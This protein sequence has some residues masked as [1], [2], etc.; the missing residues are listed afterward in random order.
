[1]EA[2]VNPVPLLV[3]AVVLALVVPTVRGLRPVRRRALERFARRVDLPLP[4]GSH[5]ELAGRLTGRNLAAELGGCAG[6]AAAGVAGLAFGLPASLPAPGDVAQPLW[7]LIAAGAVLAGGALG[8]GTYGANLATRRHGTEGPRIARP[9]A[10]T[11]AD[12]VDPLERYGARVI[13]VA[14]VLMLAVGSA[15]AWVTGEVPVAAILSPVAIVAAALA[16]VALVAG[17]LAGRRL[18][19][20]P[21]VAGSTLEL[22][23]SDAIRAR[24]LRD[25]TTTPLALGTYAS[26]GVLLAASGTIED[27]ALSNAAAGLAGLAMYGLLAMAIANAI[28]RPQRHF[29]RRLWPE[30][31]APE[32]ATAGAAR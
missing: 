19:D 13:S 32:V 26:F 21:Q 11:L 18:L 1:V 22:A 10:P 24:I 25:V 8:A 14:P 17:E 15:L 31:D 6:M 16:L 2:L 12:Y 20:Q 3:A 4:D 23:W 30:E 28:S 9:T 27:R 29:R 5:D 7:A